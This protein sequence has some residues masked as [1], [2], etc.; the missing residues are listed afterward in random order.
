VHGVGNGH[1]AALA[2]AH[3]PSSSRSI[4]IVSA[5]PYRSFGDCVDPD[6]TREVVGKLRKRDRECVA[7][8]QRLDPRD[9]L[10]VR[11]A[12]VD[13]E[14]DGDGDSPVRLPA[15]PSPSRS[16]GASVSA[17]IRT[18]EASASPLP[19]H[20]RRRSPTSRRAGA[21]TRHGH[22][23]AVLVAGVVVG[24]EAEPV[25]TRRNLD[26]VDPIVA[27]ALGTV[28]RE[29]AVVVGP[30]H[31]DAVH[32]AVVHREVRGGDAKFDRLPLVGVRAHPLAVRS[33][34][35][36]ERQDVRSGASG[37]RWTTGASGRLVSPG[38]RSSP[39]SLLPLTGCP[40]T[41]ASL[42]AGASRRVHS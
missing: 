12:I 39:S 4:R 8:R 17:T 35:G 2:G 15:S 25:A 9:C 28:A 30:H 21:R 14:V 24:D 13:E 11:I 38:T 32:V 6:P 22:L 37:R 7:R 31:R 10:G 36:V 41:R 27:V 20:P 42:S 19:P 18:D 26:L 33:V 29:Q 34:R 5:A 1:G 40:S 23:V 16:G 3:G